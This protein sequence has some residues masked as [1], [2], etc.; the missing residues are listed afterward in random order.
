MNCLEARA[1]TTWGPMQ[2]SALTGRH[3]STNWKVLRRHGV[4]RADVLVA[5]LIVALNIYLL[6]DVVAKLF[7]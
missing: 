2:L 7:S 5:M 3:R 1:K 6:Y 4:S